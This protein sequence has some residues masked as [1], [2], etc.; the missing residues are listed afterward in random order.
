TRR[1][2]RG[3]D[4]GV[5]HRGSLHHRGVGR[6]CYN[7]R[8]G[9][10]LGRALGRAL[11]IFFKNF[12][13]FTLIALVVYSPLIV[14]AA[15]VTSGDLDVSKLRTFE[16][17]ERIGSFIMGAIVSGAVT[18]GVFQELRGSPAPLGQNIARGLSRVLSVIGVSILIGITIVLC[19]I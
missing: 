17:V 4:E 12:I 5:H 1:D 6:F 13:P 16:W 3:E 19:A 10:S 9:F 7:T 11:V 15:V 14:Y 8:M 2:D 18:F